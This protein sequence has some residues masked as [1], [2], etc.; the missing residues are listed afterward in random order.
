[1]TIGTD[2]VAASAASTDRFELAKITSGAAATS[3]FASTGSTSTSPNRVSMRRLR[4]SVKPCLA[5]WG[6]MALR[7]ASIVAG[8]GDSTARR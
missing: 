3:S 8:L 1:M 2:L 7:T 4:P 5:S 6:R